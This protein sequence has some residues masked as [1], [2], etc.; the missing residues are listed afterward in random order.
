LPLFLF[1]E[2]L[3]KQDNPTAGLFHGY[4][5]VRFFCHIFLG[6]G[7]PECQGKTNGRDTVATRHAM[8]T[9]TGHHIAYAATQAHYCMGTVEKWQ[10]FDG[11]FD[12]W[13][14]FW[15]IV[16]FF[17]GAD[18]DNNADEILVWWNK[19]VLVFFGKWS[20]IVGA[21]RFFQREML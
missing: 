16:D 19:Y 6:S 14:F 15:S 4:V 10:Q 13:R 7:L 8:T 18:K 2:D 12:L 9:V 1:D 21:E 17:E 5:L 3:I 20:N 11:G